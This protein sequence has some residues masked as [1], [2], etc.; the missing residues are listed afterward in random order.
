MKRD[1]RVRRLPNPVLKARAGSRKSEPATQHTMFRFTIRDVLWLTVVVAF[2]VLWG[3]EMRQRGVENAELR[4]TNSRLLQERDAA[5]SRRLSL[6]P[7]VERE[8]RAKFREKELSAE[9]NP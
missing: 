4:E 9:S 7:L 8:F 5:V 3:M 1:R 6:M 2:A